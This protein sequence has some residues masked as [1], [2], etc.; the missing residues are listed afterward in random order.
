MD[1]FIQFQFNE[2]LFKSNQFINKLNIKYISINNILNNNDS[3]YIVIG[4]FQSGKSTL[5]NNIIDYSSKIKNNKLR[6]F[7]FSCNENNINKMN[8]I[9][10]VIAKELTFENLYYFWNMIKSDGSICHKIELQDFSINE[11]NI[12][13]YKNILLIDD[14]DE[15][16]NNI[17][18]DLTNNNFVGNMSLL[19]AMHLLLTDIF[20]KSKRYNCLTFSFINKWSSIDINYQLKNFIIMDSETVMNINSS[21]YIL[22]EEIKKTVNN[23]FKFNE[24]NNPIIIKNNEIFKFKIN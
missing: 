11:P 9:K 23:L 14:I 15:T 17:N 12:L 2:S 1:Q 3:P 6:I 19:K 10:N 4:K 18:L 16:L 24:L 5:C 13:N 20:I 7:Y 8:K 21:K 22:N